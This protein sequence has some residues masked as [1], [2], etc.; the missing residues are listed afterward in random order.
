M[1]QIPNNE[2]FITYSNSFEFENILLA[3]RKKELFNIT[4]VPKL[5]PFNENA[6]CWL[7]NRKQLTISKVKELITNIPVTKDLSDLQWYEQINLNQV[8]NL[9]N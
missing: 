3:F 5:I 9:K 6:N 7:V 8:F 4:D 2:F 1:E